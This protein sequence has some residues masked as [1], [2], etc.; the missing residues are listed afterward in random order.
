MGG[1][2]Q[3]AA[4]GVAAPVAGGRR[5]ALF[6]EREE[7]LFNERD[8]IGRPPAARWTAAASAER[9]ARVGRVAIAVDLIARWGDEFPIE[10]LGAIERK[11][12]SVR[13]AWSPE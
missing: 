7:A 8:R 2:A 10:A 11:R 9:L 12:A 3:D 13:L 4:I 5:L 6:L 1:D